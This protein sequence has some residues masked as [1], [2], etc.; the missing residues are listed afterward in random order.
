MRVLMLASYITKKSF[1]LSGG[2]VLGW[3]RGVCSMDFSSSHVV[4]EGKKAVIFFQV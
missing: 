3:L 4:E 2:I 1:Q